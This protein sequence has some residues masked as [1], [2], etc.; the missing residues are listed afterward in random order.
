MTK[1]LF[2]SLLLVLLLLISS[3][4]Q[5]RLV[6]NKVITAKKS[7]V[8]IETW[9]Q[10]CFEGMCTDY[11]LFSYGS[12]SVITRNGRTF[13][14]TAEHVCNP[15]VNE[16]KTD[17]VQEIKIKHWLIDIHNRKHEGK[18][19]KHNN[20]LDICAMKFNEGGDVLPSLRIANTPPVYTEKVYNIS[21][22][23]GLAEKG[24]VPVFEGMYSGEGIWRSYFTIPTAPGASGSPIIN[25]DAE[26]VGVV[27]AVHRSFHHITVSIKFDDLW[28]FLLLL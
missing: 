1:N 12:G 11:A 5:Q 22:P 17:T 26:L 14:L 3:C 10:G 2:S 23:L 24:M 6:N 9:V 18:L 21:S 16:L 25:Q 20:L 15:D 4:T 13:I 7:F 8:K 28:N 19:I 27:L